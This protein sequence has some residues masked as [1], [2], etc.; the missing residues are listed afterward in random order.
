MSFSG[1]SQATH[2]LDSDSPNVSENPLFIQSAQ[3][4]LCRPHGPYRVR[5]R[6]TY[7]HTENIKYTQFHSLNT[8]KSESA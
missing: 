5:G 4:C 8:T 7:T 1:S 6:R 2:E 3:E